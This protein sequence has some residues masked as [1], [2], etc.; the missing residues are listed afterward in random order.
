MEGFH[1]SETVFSVIAVTTRLV[2]VVGANVSA[3]GPGLSAFAG[4]T[5]RSLKSSKANPSKPSLSS[6]AS[7]PLNECF[8]SYLLQRVRGAHDHRSS[9][10]IHHPLRG[11]FL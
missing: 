2:G 7:V 6:H 5:I 10:P 4:G 1:F 9:T 3:F 11:N 8:F